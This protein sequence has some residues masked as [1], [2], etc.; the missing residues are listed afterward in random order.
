MHFHFETD[1]CGIV[2]APKSDVS[3]VQTAPKKPS[4]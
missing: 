1:I 4:R 3:P 2:I